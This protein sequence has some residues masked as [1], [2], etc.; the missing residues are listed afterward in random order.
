[1]RTSIYNSVE[2]STSRISFGGASK[3]L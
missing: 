1:V 2:I 3:P